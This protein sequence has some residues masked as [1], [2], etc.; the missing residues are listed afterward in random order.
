M[1]KKYFWNFLLIIAMT[2]LVLYVSLKDDF[3]TVMKAIT[4]MNPWMLGLV[5]I[6]GALY[7]IVWGGAF[8]VLGKSVQPK[9]KLWD[10]VLCAFVGAFFAGIT[11][12][13]TGGQFGQAY[14]LKKQGISYADG[15]SIL[16]ADFVIYQT[17]MMIIV[18]IL[19]A[20]YFPVLI[21]Q[22]NWFYLCIIGYF[23]NVCVVLGL[24]TMALFPR[25]YV[26]LAGWGVKLLGRM[27]IL[28]DPEAMKEK[29]LTQLNEFTGEIQK[30]SSEKKVLVQCFW[31]N[32]VRL[33]L[34][35]SLP[36]FVALGMGIQENPGQIVE[37]VALSSFVSMANSFIPIPGASGGTEMMFNV[38]FSPLYGKLTNAVMILWRASSYYV[39]LALGGL[40]FMLAKLYYDRRDARL[41]KK[42]QKQGIT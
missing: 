19:F 22:S 2:V 21:N 28:K 24:Y 38:L 1:N 30:L 39:V 12:S 27:H 5:I 40:L 15:A 16:W 25:F 29:W 13:S 10:G 34:L 36:Y 42:R 20:L 32:V 11:P 8:Y 4:S 7:T 23:V 6:W 17:T 33:L 31:I 3:D 18:T 37:V 26:W 35:Y 9:Y 41:E 14:V